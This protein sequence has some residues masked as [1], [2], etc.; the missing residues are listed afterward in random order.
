MGT[1]NYVEHDGVLWY[2]GYMSVGPQQG[3]QCPCCKTVYA[4]WVRSCAC[5]SEVSFTATDTWQ[6]EGVDR[7]DSGTST[8]HWESGRTP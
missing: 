4:P 5:E 7:E 3:W 1:D 6:K 2:T 8:G